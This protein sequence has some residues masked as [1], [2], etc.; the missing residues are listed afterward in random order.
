MPETSF[1]VY[2][3]PRN[4]THH[5]RRWEALLVVMDNKPFSDLH[6]ILQEVAD[7]RIWVFAEWVSLCSYIATAKFGNEVQRQAGPVAHA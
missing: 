5:D 7:D 3:Y 4:R 1:Q 2:V 6:E